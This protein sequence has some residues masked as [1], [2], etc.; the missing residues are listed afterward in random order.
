MQHLFWDGRARSLEEQV[1]GPIVSPIEMNQNPAHLVEKL[2]QVPEYQKR[3]KAVFDGPVTIDNISMAIA[4]FERT[5]VSRNVP[6]D[7][8]LRGDKSALSAEQIAG[9][10]LFTTKAG[11]V[12]CHYGP[13]LTDQRFHALC[14]PETEPLKK[15][16]DRIATRHFFAREQGYKGST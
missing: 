6:F 2:S 3:F 5:V 15:E 16:S 12:Q 11:C 14:V 4:A 1:K 8:Y 9:L 7:K 10:K 13:N